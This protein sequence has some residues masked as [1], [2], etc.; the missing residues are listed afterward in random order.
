MSITEHPEFKAIMIDAYNSAFKDG[1]IAERERCTKILSEMGG[2]LA[3]DQEEERESGIAAI[4][5]KIR[6]GK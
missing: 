5:A 1:Q 3:G 2:H 4:L 6:S